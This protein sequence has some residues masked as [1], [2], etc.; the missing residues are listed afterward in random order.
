MDE[1]VSESRTLARGRCFVYL[2]A[3][4]EQDTQKI[5]FA[6]DPWARMQAFHPR[7]H[8]F[9]DLDRGTLIEADRVGS[10]RSI[11]ARLKALFAS[12][13]SG[14]PLMTRSRAG[15]K[16]EWFRGIDA[17]AMEAMLGISQEFGYALH[18]PLAPWLRKQWMQQSAQIRDWTQ[19]RFELIEWLHFN[20]DPVQGQQHAQALRNRLE[21]WD[22][23]G[24]SLES[25]LH[26]RPWHWFHH[27]FDS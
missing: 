20:A 8:A 24:I 1:D 6:R 4:R 25:L 7:F 17:A 12:A 13:R 22:A 2:L 19:Q 18:T 15:G 21:A 10:A 9:F 23:I 26:T 5:G 11:E 3:C 14:A 16:S 27:G